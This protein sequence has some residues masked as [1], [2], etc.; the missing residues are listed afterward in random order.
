MTPEKGLR[1]DL[2]GVIDSKTKGRLFHPVV[3][4]LYEAYVRY[5]IL[6][7]LAT[8]ISRV[9]QNQIEPIVHT[10]TSHVTKEKPVFIYLLGAALSEGDAEMS[11]LVAASTDLLWCLSLIYDDIYDK[12]QKRAGRNAAWVE[13]GKELAYSSAHKGF[14]AVLGVLGDS[15]GKKAAETTHYYVYK[16]VDSLDDH[17][18]IGL[19]SPLNQI[20]ENYIERAHFHTTLPVSLMT[21]GET[22]SPSPVTALEAITKV[23]LA[24]QILNDVKD[25]SPNFGWIRQGLSDVRTGV[26]T[27]PLAMLWCELSDDEKRKFRSI[28]GSDDLDQEKHQYII[29]LIRK[30]NTIK[31]TYEI[32][33]E[34]YQASANA[35]REVLSPED[36]TYPMNWIEYKRE[37]V[38][39]LLLTSEPEDNR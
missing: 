18:K 10:L 37:Q 25:L 35:F 13:F 28:F 21:L 32:I 12:D 20:I 15:L 8:I 22:R 26:V 5:N 16:G 6:D 2:K 14:E 24:G 29:S 27:L 33:E 9:P 3:G 11:S 38:N 17:Q 30:T 19:D 1:E 23:N 39:Q 31:R 7:K 36:L 4:E 34:Y